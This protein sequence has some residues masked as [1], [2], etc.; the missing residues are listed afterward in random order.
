VRHCIPILLT[1]VPSN[2]FPYTE[3]ART[4]VTEK[5]CRVIAS[6]QSIGVLVAPAENACHVISK[7][8]C[9]VTSFRMG[10]LHGH[11]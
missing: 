5:T 6:S 3:A 2:W 9:G 11:K 1:A 8:S 4:R 7:H 10:K